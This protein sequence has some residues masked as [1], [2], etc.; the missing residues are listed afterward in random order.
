M[1]KAIVKTENNQAVIFDPETAIRQGTIAAKKLTEIIEAK[2]KKVIIQGNQYLT[3]EDWQV[4][5]RFYGITAGT[6]KTEEIWRERILVGFLANA[7]ALHNGVRISGAE[8]SCMRDE[9]KRKK[10]GTIV[11]PW[12]DK[13]EFQL[14]SMA[15]TRACAKSLRNVLAWV[16]ILAGY[17][18]TPAEEIN[19]E[20]KEVTATINGK[21]KYCGAVGQY[22]KPGCLNHTK[23]AKAVNSNLASDKQKKMIF[24]LSKANGIEADDAKETFKNRYSLESFNDLTK[25]QA[26]EIID[27]FQEF[28]GQS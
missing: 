13:P 20:E 21:C 11:Y 12:K 28:K 16:V 3:Y 15:Q 18:P 24:A 1:E 8:A 2:P 7:E 22:H 27:G 9:K 5:G 25:S 23:Q 19:G 4:L 14:R 26:S 10:D 6:L 17:R